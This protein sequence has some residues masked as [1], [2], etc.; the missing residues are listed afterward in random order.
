MTISEILMLIQTII[1]FL[2][3]LVLVKYTIETR[4]MREEMSKQYLILAQQLLLTQENKEYERGKELSLIQPIFRPSGGRWHGEGGYFE[5]KNHGEAIKNVSFESLSEIVA[6]MR[7]KAYMG[8]GEKLRIDI[9]KMPKPRPAKFPFVIQYEDKL[10][11]RR[12][13]NFEYDFEKIQMTEK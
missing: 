3:G 6:V 2:T 10:G 7:P 4:R 13:K 11:N 5:F 8:T 1:L 12:S 9:E